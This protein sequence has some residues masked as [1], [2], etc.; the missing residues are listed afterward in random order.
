[1]FLSCASMMINELLLER[2]RSVLGIDII[3]F[4]HLS[5]FS[6]VEKLLHKAVINEM[7]QMLI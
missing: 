2:Q 5:S 3:N 7:P 1:M 6:Q 4:S